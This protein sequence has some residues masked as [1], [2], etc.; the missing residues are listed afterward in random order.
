MK[1]RTLVL[2]VGAP[3]SGKT[4]AANAIS[5]KTGVSVVSSD[6]VRE[7]L[8]GNE[9]V[10]GK[11]SKVFEE[12]FRQTN[13]HLDTSG[14]CILDA[15]NCEQ[16]A[17]WSAIAHTLPTNIFYVLMEQNPEILK[18][19][20]AARERK[21]PEKVIDKMLHS[22]KKNYPT[23]AEAKNLTIVSYNECDALI[24]SISSSL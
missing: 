18:E 21:V 7:E 8:Y 12:V 20:N 5:A 16:W 17:R 11:S 2:M 6:K 24:A 13:S 1:Q 23:E 15:T 22:L 10:Q 14:I 4:T 19:R 3:G 9:A